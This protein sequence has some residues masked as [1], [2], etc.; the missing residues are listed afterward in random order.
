MPKS[1]SAV[2]TAQLVAEIARR[3]QK[4]LPRLRKQAAKLVKQLAAINAQ[5]AELGGTVSAKPQAKPATK[6]KGKTKAAAGGKRPRNKI[7]LAE[8]I[9]AVLS[10][11]K[12]MNAKQIIAAVKNNGYKTTSGNFETIVYQTLARE[13]KRVAKASRGHYVLKG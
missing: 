1:I 9:L 4:Q 11:D 8:A 10:K 5:I 6:S 3:Q 13:K 7:S 2:S 12:P